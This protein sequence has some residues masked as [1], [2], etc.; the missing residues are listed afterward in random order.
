MINDTAMTDDK[1]AVDRWENEG[2]KIPSTTGGSSAGFARC[3]LLLFRSSRK[4]NNRS[5]DGR[6]D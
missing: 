6:H 3:L 2:G 1:T 5:Q 4:E